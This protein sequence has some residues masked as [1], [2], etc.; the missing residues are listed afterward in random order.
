[1]E[2]GVCC[3]P[4]QV[5]GRV[6]LQSG[7]SP[8]RYQPAVSTRHERPLHRLTRPIVIWAALLVLCLGLPHQLVLCTGPHC[9]GALEFVHASGACCASHHERSEPAPV[10]EAVVVAPCGR[11]DHGDSHQDC[12]RREDGDP[13]G[14][15][16]RQGHHGCHDLP[17][18]VDE[19]PLPKRSELAAA[20][21]QLPPACW[22]PM[23][24]M[25]REAVQLPPPATG[26]PRPPE[27]LVCRST[28]VLQL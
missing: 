20:V 17:L 8:A 9:D 6:R 16:L 5:R 2:P 1:M 27:L 4:G 18:A 26:P 21:A 19:G 22:S 3:R 25:P 14:D 15:A 24:P 11:C 12:E 23:P 7:S 13:D 10:R 28:I